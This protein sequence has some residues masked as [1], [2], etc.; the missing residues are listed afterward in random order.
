MASL[1]AW[2]RR[3]IGRALDEGQGNRLAD[4]GGL[5]IF[6]PPLV[7]IADGDDRI[8]DIFREVVA[9]G[10]FLPRE[11]LERERPGAREC[12]R[13]RVVAWALPFREE[14]RRSNRTSEWPSALY[15][16]AR[17]NGG[18]WNRGLAGRLL[19]DLRK[20]GFSAVA[21]M[22]ADTYDVFRLP[23][24][25]FGSTWSER[26][27]AYAAGL[28]TFGLNGFLITP[29]G[30]MVR[31]GSLVTDAPLDVGPD[32]PADYRAA[33]LA[34][35]GRDCG[36]CLGR[37]PAGALSTA[38]LGQQACYERRNEIR[39][40][41]LGVYVERYRMTP[42]EIVKSG[43]RTPGISLGCAL[44]ASGVPCEDRDPFGAKEGPSRA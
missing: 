8:F 28:G 39:A 15:S 33:C 14:I 36:L 17:N 18:A 26:H 11:I 34:D 13:V 35:G 25:V 30:A 12:A 41:S 5:R 24:A 1:D 2:L 7:G 38:G 9:P 42:A 40:R 37:C 31:L 16:V 3:A 32:R 10:H 4:F 27:V 21:P 20:E 29:L 6:D 43:K 19:E 23:G 44:C 22:L